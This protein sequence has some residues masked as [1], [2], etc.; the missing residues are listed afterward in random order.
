MDKKKLTIDD[1]AQLTGHLSDLI[2]ESGLYK[3]SSERETNP[4]AKALYAAIALD[5]LKSA[6]ALHRALIKLGV[7]GLGPVDY[8]CDQNKGG[9]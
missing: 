1:L 2:A 7:P 8:P 6:R 5:L 4:D 3:I 9:L